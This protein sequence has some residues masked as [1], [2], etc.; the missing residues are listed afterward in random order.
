MASQS[1]SNCRLVASVEE[2]VVA[3]A[4]AMSAENQVISSAIAETLVAA[5]RGDAVG[6]VMTVTVETVVIVDE[7]LLVDVDDR[8]ALAGAAADRRAR[9]VVNDRLDASDR[10]LLVGI[11]APFV[12]AL[13]LLAIAAQRLVEAL[14]ID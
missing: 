9:L 1:V 11:A 3:T 14:E 7:A 10:R 2:V 13:L 5:L 6:T 12:S 4:S 8:R